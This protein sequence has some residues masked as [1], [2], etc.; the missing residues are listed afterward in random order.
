MAETIT[1]R[2]SSTPVSFA[3]LADLIP[4]KVGAATGVAE[5]ATLR[6]FIQAQFT[7][8]TIT[9]G[10]IT[11]NV[12]LIDG[13]VTWNNGAVA[14]HLDTM[15]AIDT[16]SAAGSTLI[17]RKLDGSVR[18]KVGSDGKVTAAGYLVDS[19]HFNAQTGTTYTLLA[20]DNG[21]TVTMDNSDPSTVTVPGSLGVGFR[22][23]V[24]QIGAGQVEFL[25]SGT[26]L[27]SLNGLAKISGQH[28]V[29]GVLATIANTLT[30][31]GDLSA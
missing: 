15:D 29:A 8:I 17:E 26:T 2:R 4:A 18:F 14:F 28:G 27:N 16:A 25:A 19:T 6:D 24:I 30:L 21:G 10:T 1:E 12:P 20:S 23:T 31:A 5:A 3:N 9:G 7:K 11:S 13:A 22:C